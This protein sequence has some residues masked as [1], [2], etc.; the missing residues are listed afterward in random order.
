ME[1][2]KLPMRQGTMDDISREV[3]TSS[4][5]DGS[6]ETPTDSTSTQGTRA[7]YERE[8][9][10]LIDYSLLLDDYKEVKKLSFFWS[11]EKKI[12]KWICMFAILNE[13]EI[14]KWIWINFF[15]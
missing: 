15:C 11:I 1:G 9:Q 13:P 4:A 3:E 14:T 6:Q 5:V 7:M 12:E 10:I 2:I 8:A